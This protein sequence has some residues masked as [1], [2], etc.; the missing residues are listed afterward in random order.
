MTRRRCWVV[1][2]VAEPNT[3]EIVEIY[4]YIVAHPDEWDQHRYGRRTKCG[5]AYCFAGHAAVR[6][7]AEPVWDRTRPGGPQEFAYVITPAGE[8]VSAELF[9]AEVLGL[10]R[11]D[12]WRL[13]DPVN[14]L[15]DLRRIVI[16]LTGVDPES[17][18]PAVAPSSV[19]GGAR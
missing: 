11:Q 12:G 5:T 15:D 3:H 13:F 17:G 7:G 2:P 4:R 16:E 8:G 18:E 10:P 9:A 19:P 6:A 14:T 1:S